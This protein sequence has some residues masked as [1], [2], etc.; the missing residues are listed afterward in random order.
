MKQTANKK[1][2]FGILAIAL[3]FAMTAVGCDSGGGSSSGGNN[4]LLG[5]GTTPGTSTPSATTSTSAGTG[6]IKIVNNK[7]VKTFS[8]LKKGQSAT[9]SGI[10]VGS[11]EVRVSRTG[12]VGLLWWKKSGVNVTRDNT[13]GVV[14]NS[15]GWA[16]N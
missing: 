6:S 14:V 1:F 3:V 10:P 8:N 9:Y 13:T 7:T 5:G 11:C 2:L 15:S 12:T 4:P 16:A